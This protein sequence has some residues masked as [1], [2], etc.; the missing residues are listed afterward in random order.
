MRKAH[1][2]LIDWVIIEV[3]L[4]RVRHPFATHGCFKACTKRLHHFR[5]S[6]EPAE[7][8]SEPS[9]ANAPDN[10]Y[11]P[12]YGDGAEQYRHERLIHRHD[13]PRVQNDPNTGPRLSRP[14]VLRGGADIE[15]PADLLLS[16]E[17]PRPS[18]ATQATAFIRRSSSAIVARARS[19]TELE[20]WRIAFRRLSDPATYRRILRRLSDLLLRRR[21]SVID[22][23]D[24][25]SVDSRG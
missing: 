11:N 10:S 21:D 12:S 16:P 17:P 3:Y 22:D 24:G 18:F 15:D 9:T 20:T 14:L 2:R 7:S 13:G 4:N 8:D 1:H 25:Q 5:V 6:S 19:L 23:E